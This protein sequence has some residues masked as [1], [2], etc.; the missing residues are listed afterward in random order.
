MTDIQV[1]SKSLKA[2]WINPFPA[3]DEYIRPELRDVNN[4]GHK[5]IRLGIKHFYH[6]SVVPKTDTNFMTVVTKHLLLYRKTADQPTQGS[7]SKMPHVL[8][9]EKQNG[10]AST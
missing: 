10:V 7:Y 8:S 6:C 5:Y 4:P 2:T 3:M 1:F 9:S